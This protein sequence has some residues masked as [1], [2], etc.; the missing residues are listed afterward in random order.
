M[1]KKVWNKTFKYV[2][3]INMGWLSSLFFCEKRVYFVQ[4]SKIGGWFWSQDYNEQVI[5]L[6]TRLKSAKDHSN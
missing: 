2:K 3:N 6:I 5:I 1:L 4:F